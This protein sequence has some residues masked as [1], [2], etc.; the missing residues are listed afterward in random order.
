M[1]H[2]K[3]HQTNP[4]APWDPPDIPLDPRG[5]P[6]PPLDLLWTQVTRSILDGS[7]TVRVWSATTKL[8]SWP[9]MM[10]LN[11]V[12]TSTIKIADQKISF[13]TLESLIKCDQMSQQQ[14][15]L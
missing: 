12:T 6:G 5:L 2:Q 4:M 13:T 3:T 9:H 11:I 7:S 10:N 8:K 1:N 14:S 15:N